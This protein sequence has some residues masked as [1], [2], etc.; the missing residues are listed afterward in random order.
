LTGLISPL[1]EFLL[2]VQDSGEDVGQ[3]LHV[4]LTA[5]FDIARLG[6]NEFAPEFVATDLDRHVST[7]VSTEEDDFQIFISYTDPLTGG[8]PVPRKGESAQ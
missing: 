4:R 7:C 1:G 3:W 6:A 5:S 8:T 2:S